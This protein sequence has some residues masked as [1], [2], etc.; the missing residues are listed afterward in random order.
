[1]VLVGR[2]FSKNDGAR[3]PDFFKQMTVLVGPIFSKKNGPGTAKNTT[4]QL[5]RRI[6]CAGCVHAEGFRQ[7]EL[8]I[9]SEK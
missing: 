4:L 2:I 9:F 1:M 7:H 3:G 6:L 5:A 8:S